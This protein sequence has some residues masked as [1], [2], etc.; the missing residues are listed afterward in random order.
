M[1]NLIVLFSIVGIFLGCQLRVSESN[2]KADNYADNKRIKKVLTTGLARILDNYPTEQIR[3]FL[4]EGPL[5][6][7]GIY[8]NCYG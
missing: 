8:L 4:K 3:G 5:S 6:M 1:K 2:I 7:P